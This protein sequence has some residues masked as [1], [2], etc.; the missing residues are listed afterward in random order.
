MFILFYIFLFCYLI[1]IREGG[2]FFDIDYIEDGI[3]GFRFSFF[4]FLWFF[5]ESVI[6]RENVVFGVKYVFRFRF[7]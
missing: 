5:F 2:V 7:I 3:R 4:C 1:Y 6:D